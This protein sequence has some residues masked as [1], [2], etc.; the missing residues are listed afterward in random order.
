MGHTHADGAVDIFVE[1]VVT[2]IR[3]I[4]GGDAEEENAM[5]RG[6]VA[7]LT[8]DDRRAAQDRRALNARKFLAQR[9]RCARCGDSLRPTVMRRPHILRPEEPIVCSA[10]YGGA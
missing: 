9:G 8:A 3:R 6:V 10:C 5:R 7:R 4:A 1:H 2:E